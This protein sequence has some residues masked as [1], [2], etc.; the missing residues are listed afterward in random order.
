MTMDRVR[1][2]LVDDEPLARSGLRLLCEKDPELDLVCE[3]SNGKAAVA[4]IEQVE[5]DLL[6]LDIQMPE[7]DG[8]EVLE[9]ISPERIPQVIFVT[10]YDRFAIRAFEIR[11]LDYLL[12]PFDDE[13]FFDAVERAKQAVRSPD[14]NDIRDRVLDLV[15]ATGLKAQGGNTAASYR[16]DRE[17]PGKGYP[18]RIAIKEKG[19]I[20]LVHFDEI[21]WI[22]AADYRVRIHATHKSFILRES[23][24]SIEGRL[25]PTRFLRVSRSA[26]VNLDRI[27]EIQPFARG[28][29]MI[30]LESGTRVLLS[31][32]RKEALEAL[33]DRRL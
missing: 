1:V 15:S 6:L 26:I 33:L 12:K 27:K 10:A 4:A 2:I 29:H 14:F 11:A 19:R 25:D 21:D 28:S 16:P 3:C 31:R 17:P 20:Y 8:F 24:R 5:P 7:M 32:S 18:V 9:A 13:R 22:E 23:M 30:I